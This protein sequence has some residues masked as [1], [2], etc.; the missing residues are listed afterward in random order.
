[1]PAPSLFR[2]ATVAAIALGLTAAGAGLA[3]AAPTPD[4]GPT[5]GG[6]VVGDVLP[7]FAFTE[8]S[9]GGAFSVALGQ[10]GLLY[11]WGQ[12]A[13]G[14]LGNGAA[15]T[16]AHTV[17][18]PVD[19]PSGVTFTQVVAGNEHALALGSDGVLYAWGDNV[20]GQLGNGTLTDSPSPT[21]VLLPPGST[22]TAL[23]AGYRHSA[24]LLS[25]G[26]LL[27]WG[28]NA[29]GQL[30][31]GT[32]IRSST[33]LPVS[34]P[35]GVGVT[36]LTAGSSQGSHMLVIGT[37]G[38]TY[39]WGSNGSGQV[40]TGSLGGVEYL[41]VLVQAPA[42][43]RFV[44]VTAGWW[45]S[46]AIADDGTLWSW[47]ANAD[48]QLGTGTVL[49]RYA[50]GPVSADPALRFTTIT[51]SIDTSAALSTDGVVYSWGN[52]FYGVIGDG[53][54][55]TSPDVR[56]PTPAQLPAGTRITALRQGG[57][58]VNAIA[59]DGTFYSW[60]T[61]PGL[62]LGGAVTDRAPTP[63]VQPVDLTVD[64]VTFGGVPGTAV[65]PT[66]GGWTATTPGGC[67]PV[68]VTVG[69]R[70]FGGP[71]QQQTTPDG[72]SYGT[73]P[74]IVDQPESV[75][76]GARG[77]ATVSVTVTGD[78]APT[79]Q[80][81]SRTGTGPWT[82]LAGE[83]A[84]SLTVTPAATE[85][86]RAVVTNCLGSV[87]S[88]AATLTVAAG[89]GTRPHAD[90]ATP[91]GPAGP[92]GTTPADPGSTGVRTLAITGGEA[93]GIAGIAALLTAAG[94]LLVLGRR[95]AH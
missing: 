21:P 14:Q 12:D 51:S 34:M 44:Q 78:D 1:M 26:T 20:D 66:A 79:I 85:D 33:P 24:A 7:G 95:R 6:T 31:S 35:P 68:D 55:Q 40:G 65:A 2:R 61:G 39:G 60:G 69:Y 74:A 23:A 87:T 81:Q 58:Q 93:A 57:V 62:G 83:T 43:V 10:D 49:T 45:H 15:D 8:V 41:P 4:G 71:V 19:T 91:A 54:G 67:G 17:P 13:Q 22:V 48:G 72:F 27:M 73:L 25:D 80:W 3:H 9:A 18:A 89:P 76:V 32:F 59:D 37:D 75:Q 38:Q 46:L 94:T 86:V 28:A 84:D 5:A 56:V 50:P 30:G 92:A 42:G 29:S 64:Q 16:A 77:S 82:D 88:D 90:P 52:P 70:V 53:S 63:T 47:G 36:T 11:S